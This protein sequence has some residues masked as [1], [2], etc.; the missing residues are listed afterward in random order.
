MRSDSLNKQS[1]PLLIHREHIVAKKIGVP[2]ALG[3][4]TRKMDNRDVRGEREGGGNRTSQG[5]CY[6]LFGHM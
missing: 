4:R 1:I 6:L 2:I 5:A 3:E